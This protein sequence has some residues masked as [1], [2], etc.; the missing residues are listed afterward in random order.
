[1][2]GKM[3]NMKAI[4]YET[5][6]TSEVLKEKRVLIPVPESNEVLIRVKATS[7]TSA[8][9]KLRQANPFLVRLYNGFLKPKNKILGTEFSGEIFSVGENVKKYKKG[10]EVFGFCGFG[11]YSEYICMPESGAFTLKPESLTHSE[12][13]TIPFGALSALY[14]LK[15]ANIN[16][17]QRVMIYGASGSVGTYAIQLAKIFNAYV[18]AVC[19]AKNIPLTISVGA[20]KA[21]NYNDEFFREKLGKQD[22]IF[23]TVGK[24]SIKNY[25]DRILPGGK[26]ASTSIDLELVKE[27]FKSNLK[28]NRNII[29]GVASETKKDLEFLK[30][31]IENG[32]I[33]PVIDRSYTID[34]IKIAHEYVETGK[35]RGN[36]VITV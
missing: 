11:S 13:A 33:K 28:G 25:K 29:I 20:D 6:G 12:A 34:Q 9:I 27:F 35:K 30:D 4:V 36:L 18:T 8:D 22:L 1:M 10:D 5:Y 17:G 2:N 3:M 23:D 31:L 16:T 14:F 15:K 32:M 21:L 26:F 7:V 19:S 24:L